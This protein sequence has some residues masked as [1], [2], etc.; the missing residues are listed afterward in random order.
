MIC[1]AIESPTHSLVD[2]ALRTLPTVLPILDF[3]TIKNELFPVVATVFSKTSSLGIKV[4]GLEAFLI[5][6]GGS[7]D[8]HTSSDGLDGM[9]GNA[10]KKSTSSA[11][12]KYTMQEKIVPLIKAIKTKEPAVMVAALNVMRHVGT[13]A[14]PEFVAVDILP[15]LWS[16]SLGPLLNLQQFQNFM[17]LIKSLSSRVEQEQTK[18]LHEMSS[19]SG[20]ASGS[21][22]MPNDDFMSFGGVTGFPQSHGADSTDDDFERLVQG[23]AGAADMVSNLTDNGWDTMP[24]KATNR[25]I[26]NPAEP[27]KPASFSWSTPSPTSQQAFASNKSAMNHVISPQQNPASRTVTPDLSRFDTLSPS[28]T[29]F[30]QPLQPSSNLWNTTPLQPQPSQQQHLA[31]WAPPAPSPW[32][33]PSPSQPSVSS[34]GNIKATMSALSIK[35]PQ[36]PTPSPSGF[37]LPPPP[38]SS[39]NSF[40]LPPPPAASFTSYNAPQQQQQQLWG[41]MVPAATQKSGLDAFESLL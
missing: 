33:A 7:A 36:R 5:L 26:S 11:L 31:N 15:T 37:S 2:A 19:T 12:D 16:M 3:S 28:T 29:Q 38:L 20:N 30:S 13:V 21:R 1:L 10:V 25:Q 23:K 24:A 17:E 14:D 39:N 6:C 27:P 9:S 40:S 8:P 4:R 41:T 18:K 32:G 22:P 34:Y 35:Q